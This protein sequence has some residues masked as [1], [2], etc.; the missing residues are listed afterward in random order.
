VLALSGC[1]A[2]PILANEIPLCERCHGGDGSAAPP[3]SATGL[4]DTSAR[5]VGAHQRHLALQGGDVRAALPCDT[6]HVVPASVDAHVDG[7]V[8]VRFQDPA[9]AGGAAA[10]WNTGTG[11]CD[12]V[13]CHGAT[14][15]DG[16]RGPATAPE[17]TRVDGSQITCG[18]CHRAP[19]ASHAAYP[20]A[21]TCH[22]CHPATV[23]ADGTIDL[24]GAKHIDGVVQAPSGSTCNGCHGAPPDTGAHL[25]HA[26][27][28]DPNA[29]AYGNLDVLEDVSPSGGPA[30][31]F[32]CGH[33]HPTDSARHMDGTV[34]VD[35]A[36]PATPVAGDEIK[37]RNLATAAWDATGQACSGVYCHS[38]GQETPAFVAS[39]AWT[40]A[41]GALGCS[42]CHGNP[43][44]YASGGAGAATANSHLG[45]DDYGV[46]WGHFAGLPG[47]GHSG[48]SKHGG[49][50]PYYFD[51]PQAA[52]PITCQAC[53]ADTVDPANVMAG[54]F[55]WLDTTGDYQLAGGDPARLGSSG[56]LHGQCATCH[57]AGGAPTRAGAVLPLRHVNGKRDVVF[58]ARRS[59]PAGYA[60]GLPAFTDADPDPAIDVRPYYVSGVDAAW[61]S[62]APAPDAVVRVTTGEPV[63]TTTLE[64]A[65][66]DPASKTCSDVGCHLER[67][68]QVDAVPSTAPPLRWGAQKDASACTYC[69]PY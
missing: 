56:W 7:A 26:N 40:A 4:A 38:S 37:A 28:A 65:T 57:A 14:L 13:Y 46:E 10:R 39:P 20:G 8:P 48:G 60:T 55:F 61:S 58:D 19:P 36:P 22:T 1:Q 68:A 18:S 3:R 24:A 35:L 45:F 47:A 53:H 27:P 32:G 50:N 42:G 11:R 30:Y 25:V 16:T 2:H 69:H 67:Q 33:C 21:S 34:E 44:R 23:L 12:N 43:P 51:A 59:L 62:I 49:D 29:I 31:D 52:S 64:S 41:P 15:R 17:W 54:G 5:G 66:Y 6:C 63:Y 9:A